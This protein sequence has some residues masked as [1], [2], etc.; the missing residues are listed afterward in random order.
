MVCFANMIGETVEVWSK[1]LKHGVP[2][3]KMAQHTLE[4]QIFLLRQLA[5][6]QIEC[7]KFLVRGAQ[8]Q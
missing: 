4:W 3:V 7:Y 5:N 6:S 8:K 2:D 1:L